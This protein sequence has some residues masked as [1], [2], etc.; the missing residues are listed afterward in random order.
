MPGLGRPCPEAAAWAKLKR[1]KGLRRADAPAGRSVCR[2]P[3]LP[4]SNTAVAFLARSLL[5]Q[6]NMLLEG[7]RRNTT[8]EQ[9]AGRSSRTERL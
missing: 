3:M 6:C 7:G 4:E 8:P 5:P 9:V 2:G 1:D